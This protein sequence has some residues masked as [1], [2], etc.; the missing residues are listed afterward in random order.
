MEPGWL[1]VTDVLGIRDAVFLGAAVL[2][3]ASAQHLAQN[4]QQEVA[5]CR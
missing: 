2:S 1:L 5:S 4:K 3:S